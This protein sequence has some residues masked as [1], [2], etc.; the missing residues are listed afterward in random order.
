MY[1]IAGPYSGTLLGQGLEFYRLYFQVHQRI[2]ELHSLDPLS[3]WLRF[4]RQP[5]DQEFLATFGRANLVDT[6]LVTHA[7]MMLVFG[8]YL[9][10]LEQECQ[11]LREAVS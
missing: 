11:K 4:T 5:N 9:Q 2:L 6:R 1:S 7:D 3:P 8:N 10:A